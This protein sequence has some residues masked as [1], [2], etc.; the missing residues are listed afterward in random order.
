MRQR[1]W[2]EIKDYDLEIPYHPR[3]ANVV[4]DA[5]SR[6]R[7]YGV[8]VLITTQV[9]LLEDLRRLDIKVMVKGVVSMVASLR[10]HPSL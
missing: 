9:R 8:V 1:R 5:L 4:A 10:L 6:K 2:L 3:K 7:N